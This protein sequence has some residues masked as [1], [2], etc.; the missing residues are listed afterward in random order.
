LGFDAT[1]SGVALLWAFHEALE[2]ACS[3]TGADLYILAEL[4]SVLAGLGCEVGFR[5]L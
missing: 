1:A 5:Y 4:R 3:A 2:L